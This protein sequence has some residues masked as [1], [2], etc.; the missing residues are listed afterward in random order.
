[1]VRQEN[2]ARIRPGGILAPR[3]NV[4]ELPQAKEGAAAKRGGVEGTFPLLL[5]VLLVEN[6]LGE[7][8]PWYDARLLVGIAQRGHLDEHDARRKP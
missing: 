1:M 4:R 7:V 2:A 8:L 5:A 3:I 6:D